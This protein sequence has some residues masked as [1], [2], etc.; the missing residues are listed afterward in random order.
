MS[1]KRR[2]ATAASE[3]DVGHY[4]HTALGQRWQNDDEH[5]SPA[6]KQGREEGYAQEMARMGAAAKPSSPPQDPAKVASPQV[7]ALAKAMGDKLY[8]FPTGAIPSLTFNDEDEIVA[9]GITLEGRFWSVQ[10]IVALKL[11][12]ERGAWLWH[13]YSCIAHAL[14]PTDT[15]LRPH[16]LAAIAGRPSL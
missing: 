14:P 6:H 9:T 2:P 8:H 1:T 3:A 10:D 15:L 16:H 12:D 13:R 7:T 5:L 4:I 11:I